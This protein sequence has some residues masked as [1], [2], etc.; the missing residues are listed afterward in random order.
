MGFQPPPDRA[1]FAGVK[2]VLSLLFMLAIAVAGHVLLSRAAKAIAAA[3]RPLATGEPEVGGYERRVYG[4][5]DRAMLEVVGVVLAAGLVMWVGLT[6]NWGWVGFLGFLV[7]L[8]A[9]GLDMA[10]WEHVTASANYV[11]FQRGFGRKV[12]Q[13]AIE[14]IRDV[15]VSESDVKGFTPRHLN[16]NR[17][18]RLNMRMNDKRVV[19]LPK[20]DAYG[21]LE[22]VE[23]L[24]NH[25][26]TRQ[27][28]MG[29]RAAVKRSG[30][31]GSA[32]AARVAEQPATSDRELMR[33]LK[34][35]R[36]KAQSPELPPAV[37]RASK[38]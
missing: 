8:G 27:Q 33:E 21:E 37:K 23:T 13:V 28:L 15:S 17:T 32:T 3:A 22:A 6:W 30:D 29:D 14:N 2:H 34:R 18:C 10:R 25:I 31:E 4:T 16:R 9:V 24:A 11:W 26:R 12:H 35:L 5:A 1:T 20:T 7:L 38:A 19:A 36:Q